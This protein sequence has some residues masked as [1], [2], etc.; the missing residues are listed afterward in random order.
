MYNRD[1]PVEEACGHCT[2]IHEPLPCML[3]SSTSPIDTTD[4]HAS[5]RILLTK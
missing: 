3:Q 2:Y 4:I 1:G 5:D